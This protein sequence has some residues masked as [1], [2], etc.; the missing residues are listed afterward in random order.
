MTEARKIFYINQEIGTEVTDTELNNLSADA[1]ITAIHNS[2]LQPCRGGDG[3]LV[4]IDM[5]E[6][7]WYFDDEYPATKIYAKEDFGNDYSLCGTVIEDD[8]FNSLSAD[9]LRK[10]VTCSHEQT[11]FF[12]NSD[13]DLMISVNRQSLTPN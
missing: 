10:A 12:R 5:K 11:Y 1:L 4:L 2:K 8:E 9:E 13:G 7:A 3:K 6:D